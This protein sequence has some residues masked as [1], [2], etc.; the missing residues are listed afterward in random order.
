MIMWPHSFM[1]QLRE[2]CRRVKSPFTVSS[3]TNGSVL[4]SAFFQ[5]LAVSYWPKFTHHIPIHQTVKMTSQRMKINKNDSSSRLRRQLWKFKMLMI[6]EKLNGTNCLQ[7]QLYCSWSSMALDF[8]VF[9]PFIQ[10]WA[11]F[12]RPVFS[13]PMFTR[14]SFPQFH[15][16]LPVFRY[17]SSV[18]WLHTW[19]MLTSN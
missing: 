10:T 13:S 5:L 19:V 1:R 6:G 16:W 8:R 11:S 4:L 14:V 15:T 3:C 2:L 18:A 7:S 12:S 17:L 9:K